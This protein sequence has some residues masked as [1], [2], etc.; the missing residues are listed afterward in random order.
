M[1]SLRSFSFLGGCLLFYDNDL[2]L[3]SSLTP[4]LRNFFSTVVN[5]KKKSESHML[6]LLLFT[7]ST[8][9][10][11][12]DLGLATKSVLYKAASAE[13][14]NGESKYCSS[15]SHK[16]HGHTL[17]LLL[18][19]LVCHHIT[20]LQLTA[21]LKKIMDSFIIFIYFLCKYTFLNKQT[22]KSDWC[23]CNSLCSSQSDPS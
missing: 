10:D 1:C 19:L 7:T 13:L 20:T 17:V 18:S 12:P 15:S 22:P 8:F 6:L 23:C 11:F 3:C 9:T 2:N 14:L 4:P 21:Y 5:V 16:S